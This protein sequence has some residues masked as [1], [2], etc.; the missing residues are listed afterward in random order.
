MVIEIRTKKEFEEIIQ[1]D[2]SII[3]FWAEWCTPCVMFSPI[4]ESLSKKFKNIK[5]A[6]VNV[7]DNGELAGRFDINSIP[8]LLIFKKGKLVDR[9]VGALPKEKIEEKLRSI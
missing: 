3:D 9:I 7:D 2:I 6:K 8:C 5:F 4:F 1:L